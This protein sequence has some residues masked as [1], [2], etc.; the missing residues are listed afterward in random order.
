MIEEQY[1]IRRQFWWIAKEERKKEIDTQGAVCV[2]VC[3]RV[4]KYSMVCS[5]IKNYMYCVLV[6]T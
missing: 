1:F 3:G 4:D 2:C 5:I 6:Y